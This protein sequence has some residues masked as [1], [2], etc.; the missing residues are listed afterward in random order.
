M[1]EHPAQVEASGR[2]PSLGG[3]AGLRGEGQA[4]AGTGEMRGRR[5]MHRS[6]LIYSR[7][8]RTFSL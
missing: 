1:G 5:Q 7:K 3:G 8:M 4:S 2:A 6:S